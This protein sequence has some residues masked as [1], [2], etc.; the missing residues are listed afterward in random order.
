MTT[1]AQWRSPSDRLASARAEVRPR[2]YDMRV[3]DHFY[4]YCNAVALAD[5]HRDA[6]AGSQQTTKRR[7]WAILIGASIL[8]YC[9]VERVAQA[10]SQ[11]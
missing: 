9:L 7:L 8:G 4:A 10:M 6:A 3:V 11:F 2:K 5:Q 1:F